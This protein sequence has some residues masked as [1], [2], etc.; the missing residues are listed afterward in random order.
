MSQTEIEKTLAAEERTEEARS[1][2][3]GVKAVT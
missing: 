2:V 3:H 1:F